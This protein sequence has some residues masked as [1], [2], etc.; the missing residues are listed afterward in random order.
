MKKNKV[1]VRLSKIEG[2]GLGLFAKSKITKGE[3]ISE[4]TGEL[5][6]N[7]QLEILLS[8]RKMLFLIDYDENYTLD[9]ENSNCLAKYANDAKGSKKIKGLINNSKIIFYNDKVFLV[10]TK[11][12]KRREEIYTSY[13]KEYWNNL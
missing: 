11:D 6:N 2:A 10:A 1:E 13:G 12:I 8:K 5:V 9:V 3:L 7:K 4:F